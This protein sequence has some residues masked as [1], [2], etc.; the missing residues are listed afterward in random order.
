MPAG[1]VSPIPGQI[2]LC[3]RCLKSALKKTRSGVCVFQGQRVCQSGELEVLKCKCTNTSNAPAPHSTVSIARHVLAQ[4][5]F[6]A[7]SA[8]TH[9]APPPPISQPQ[10]TTAS[11]EAEIV[12]KHSKWYFQPLHLAPHISKYVCLKSCYRLEDV[13]H[14]IMIRFVM[15]LIKTKHHH[16]IHMGLQC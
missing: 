15:I 1:K 6:W 14:E 10:Q 16:E 5:M 2:I 8:K 7:S 13:E 9:T 4:S 11:S 3:A 12:S